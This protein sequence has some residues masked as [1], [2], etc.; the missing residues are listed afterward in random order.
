MVAGGRALEA[1]ARRQS[2]VTG[3]SFDSGGCRAEPHIVVDRRL[4]FLCILHCCMAIGHLQ[5]ASAEARLEA[6]PRENAEAVLYQARMGVKL[7]ASA[8]P[9][10]EEARALFLAWEEMGPLLAYAPEDPE[11]QAVVA[12][13]DLLRDLYSNTPPFIDL[14]A[15]A[16]ARDYRAH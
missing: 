4:V 8:A 3:R 9:D 1:P 2:Q 5:D 7:G 16:V 11:W 10:R 6:L 13:R 15:S 12:M 14:G